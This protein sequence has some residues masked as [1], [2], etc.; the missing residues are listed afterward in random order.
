MD[1]N[2]DD[3]LLGEELREGIDEAAREYATSSF[4]GTL[5]GKAHQELATVRARP[6]S[7]NLESWIVYLDP[8]EHLDT[9]SQ[10]AKFLV[11]GGHQDKR[12]YRILTMVDCPYGSEPHF[13]LTVTPET[14]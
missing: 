4:G 6:T 3:D 5:L 14:E 9:Q 8:G 1:S 13:D 10:P 12:R 11:A 7:E 2:E